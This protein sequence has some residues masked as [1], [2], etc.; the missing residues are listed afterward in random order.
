M[1]LSKTCKAVCHPTRIATCLSMISAAISSSFMST[2][3]IFAGTGRAWGASSVIPPVAAGGCLVGGEVA[4]TPLVRVVVLAG[5]A[6]TPRATVNH[7]YFG[8]VEVVG[9]G[10]G[11]AIYWILSAAVVNSCEAILRMLRARRELGLNSHT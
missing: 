7:W 10:V 8:S 4:G 2:G 3:F 5:R 9:E 1:V 6:D 11:S